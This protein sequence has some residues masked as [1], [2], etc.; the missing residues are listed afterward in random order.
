MAKTSGIFSDVMGK[1]GMLAIIEID[2]KIL[3]FIATSATSPAFTSSHTSARS[4]EHLQ[5]LCQSVVQQPVDRLV[6]VTCNLSDSAV[7]IH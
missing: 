3:M 4:L 1:L 6:L 7:G 5:T 2:H